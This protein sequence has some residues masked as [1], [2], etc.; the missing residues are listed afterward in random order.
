MNARVFGGPR[1]GEVIVIP[2]GVNSV[3]LRD[4]GGL[5]NFT[6]YD[7][8]RFQHANGTVE[9]VLVPVLDVHI[10]GITIRAP[11]ATPVDA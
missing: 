9:S 3:R 7:L 11:Y 1:D 8:R 4:P 5:H 6:D 2:E 10:E